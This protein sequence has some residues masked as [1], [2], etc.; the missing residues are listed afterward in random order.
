MNLRGKLQPV[1]LESL[2]DRAYQAIRVAIMEGAF[3]PGEQITIRSLAEA[4]GIGTMP[5]RES[6]QRLVAEGAL[7]SLPNRTV[8]IPVLNRRSFDDLCLLRMAVE[9]LAMRLACQR[10]TTDSFAQISKSAG[11]VSER[12]HK[13]LAAPGARA[14]KGILEANYQFQFSIYRAAE[15]PYLLGVIEGLWLRFGPLVNY[16]LHRDDSQR[17]DLFSIEPVHE[18]LVAAL[19]DRHAKLAEESLRRLV[20]HTMNWYHRH[21]RFVD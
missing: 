11:V 6:I 8:R 15:S 1:V 16:P 21:Y 9:G 12:V 17:R 5:V 10:M 7:A 4:L 14:L 19:R 13:G 20:E 18:Q 3:A 2:K